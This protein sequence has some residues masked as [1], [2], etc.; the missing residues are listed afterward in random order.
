MFNFF[1]KKPTS[2]LGVDIG[3][4]SIKVV[5]LGLDGKNIKLENYAFLEDKDYLEV[6]GGVSGSSDLKIS[7][8]QV[9]EDLTEIKKEAK[10]TSDNTIMSI[11]ASSAFSSII[12]LPNM[13]E[14]E[15]AKAINYEARQY[16]PIPISE[17]VFDW[18]IISEK[19]KD[20]NH[21]KK[22]KSKI[23]SKKQIKVL[24]VAIPKEITEKYT[25]IADTLKLKLIALET[26]SFSLARSLV[27]NEESAS[28][29]VDIGNK[30]TNVTTI[31]NGYVLASHSAFGT[32]GKEIT[33][34]ISYGFN[35]DFKRADKL[36]KDIGLSFSG[37]QRKI[38]ETILPTINIIVSEVK[39]MNEIYVKN[40]K[41]TVKKIIVTG[42]TAN[43]PGLVDY[44][45][46]ELDILV[47]IGNPWKNITY[48]KALSGKLKKMSSDFSV[49][50]GLALRGFEK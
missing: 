17:V 28:I 25:A 20:D 2:F 39:K 43:L 16:I 38:S 5:Q 40:N 8:M 14:D 41:K 45:S 6:L 29:I 23:K 35:V 4:T 31:E 50:V 46:N 22:N 7:D 36:K 12:N 18:S 44:F 49:A 47:E 24:L 9:V 27:G 32:G 30:M 21:D 13:S 48:D 11:P 19:D 26:E 34:A 3:T 10:I 1:K 42:G 37:S 33:R 15:I